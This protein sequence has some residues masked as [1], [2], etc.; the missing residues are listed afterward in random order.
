MGDTP[1]DVFVHNLQRIGVIAC[2]KRG[3]GEGMEG[4]MEGGGG[5][6]RG[7]F[8]EMGSRFGS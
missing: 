1:R 7:W 3:G 2:G 5:R 6:V 4:E 8:G